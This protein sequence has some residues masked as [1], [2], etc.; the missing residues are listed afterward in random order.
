VNWLITAHS[1]EI[2][3]RRIAIDSMKNRL[4][5]LTDH[6]AYPSWSGIQRKGVDIVGRVVWIGVRVA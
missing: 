3:V 1:S 6:P 2:V 4:T 5:V